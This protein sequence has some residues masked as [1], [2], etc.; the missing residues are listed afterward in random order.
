MS[1]RHPRIVPWRTPTELAE[2]KNDFFPAQ[3]TTDR[4]AHAVSKVRAWAVR[5][6]L[7]H[8]IEA[9]ALLTEAT[10]HDVPGISDNVLRLA[11][12]SAVCRFVNGLL[13]PLQDKKFAQSMFQLAREQEL[14]A[15]FIDVRH[16][17]THGNLPSLRLLRVVVFKALQ[18]LWEHYWATIGG[19]EPATEDLKGGW[20]AARGRTLLKQWRKLRRDNPMRELKAG[21]QSTEAKEAR[22][23]IKECITL[24]SEDEGIPGFVVA[25]IE[26]KALIP[27][28]KKK[29]AIMKGALSLWTPLLQELDRAVPELLENFLK[30][31]MEVWRAAQIPAVQRMKAESMVPLFASTVNQAPGVYDVEFCEA[32][33]V[34]VK[35]IASKKFWKNGT[36]PTVDLEQVARA[37]L[38]TPN[39]WSLQVLDH[40]VTEYPKLEPKYK[41]L[42]E[43]ANLQVV[44][45]KELM[46]RPLKGAKQKDNKRGLDY[47]DAEITAYE[48]RLLALQQQWNGKTPILAGKLVEEL[49]QAGKWKR[50]KG[51][52]RPRPL[53][54]I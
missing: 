47:I 37:C 11:Y 10:L 27:A 17:A 53:G 35:H 45:S 44:S 14:P 18:W 31:T 21:D 20:I 29:A 9:T 36:A 2:V 34:W 50:E 33:C 6:A 13:D 23:I 51:P 49:G 28:G 24:C 16:D 40:L 52:W 42:V 41:P 54:V 19:D 39:E 12:S 38:V 22:N 48:E 7:P 1:F 46:K 4:R 5:G 43:L 30:T 3:D 15:M 26:E 8:S 25:L 32:L